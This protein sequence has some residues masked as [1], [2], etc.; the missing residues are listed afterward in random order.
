MFFSELVSHG[1]Y[2]IN[3]IENV[4]VRKAIRAIL[5]AFNINNI[6]AFPS[7]RTVKRL[8]L[9][10]L[11]KEEADEKEDVDSILNKSIFCSY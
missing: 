7:A 3:M 5:F 1:N 9:K 8:T 4:D 10:L 2:P 11:D 6:V